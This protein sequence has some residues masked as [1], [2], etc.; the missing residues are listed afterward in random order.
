MSLI[1]IHYLTGKAICFIRT[2]NTE[3]YYI[4]IYILNLSDC[5]LVINY[6]QTFTFSIIAYNSISSVPWFE[7]DERLRN[8]YP[9]TWGKFDRSQEN[10]FC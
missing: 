8:L 4:Y 7:S 5:S 9:T 3:V 6:C 10:D 2:V 1:S